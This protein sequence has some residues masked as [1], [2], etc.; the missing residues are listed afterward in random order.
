MFTFAGVGQRRFPVRQILGSLAVAFVLTALM[1][2]P[3]RADIYTATFT[4]SGSLFTNFYGFVLPA[5]APICSLTGSVT[6][7]SAY[8]EQIYDKSFDILFDHGPLSF[9]FTD[10]SNTW[11]N[12]SPELFGPHIV[13]TTTASGEISSWEIHLAKTGSCD[14]CT[15]FLSSTNTGS[16]PRDTTEVYFDIS[17]ER[18][19]ASGASVLDNPGTWTSSITVTPTP[20]PASFILFGSSLGTLFGIVRRK[21]R[22]PRNR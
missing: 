11:S 8:R 14:A 5:C 6:V 15:S 20:E 1:A 18:F 4:Y 12:G 17:G 7:T 19:L 2:L 16:A 21:Q 3:A 10:G 22:A 13:L 9:S